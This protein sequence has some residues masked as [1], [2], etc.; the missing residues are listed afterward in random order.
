MI[1]KTAT[2][3]FGVNYTP[4]DGWFHSWLDFDAAK[5]RADLEQIAELGCDHIR[6]FPLWP[7]LQPNRAL[8]R[9]QAIDNVCTVVELA[10]DCGLDT[11]VDVLQGHLSSFDFLPSWVVS[12]HS[13]NLFTDPAVVAAQSQ[14]V[15]TLGQALAEVPGFSGL[16]LGNEFVQFAATRHPR[17]QEITTAEAKQWLEV[18]LRQAVQVVPKRPHTFSHDDDVWFDA[19]HPFTPETAVCYGD[20]TTV[21]AWIFGRIAPHFGIG[22]REL[23]WFARYLC[24]VADAWARAFNVAQR[25]IWLQEI[26]APEHC[27]NQEDVPQFA[28]DTLDKL[29]GSSGGGMCPNLRAVTWWCSHDV[30][31]NLVDFPHF[32]HSL[33][34]FDEHGRLKPVGRAFR[35]GIKAWSSSD[36]R[37]LAPGQDDENRPQMEITLDES[38]RE[39][40]APDQDFFAKWVS[41]A[42][43]G[44]VK[45]IVINIVD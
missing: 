30:C 28:T 2:V 26:G 24:E 3:S 38:K 9:S 17:R 11:S 22:A 13:R 29:R 18:L 12:W 27:L 20:I 1:D 35:D 32:E 42:M 6:V 19:T 21:H 37:V 43:R 4:C 31:S 44:E 14:L 34:L 39:L 45:Q 41:S 15:R 8:I 36:P 33:G 5:V 23:P 7:L 16:S 25:P 40:L 10:R